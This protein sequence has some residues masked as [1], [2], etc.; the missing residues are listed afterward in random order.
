MWNSC[1][2][3]STPGQESLG[4]QC[5][6]RAPGP[7]SEKRQGVDS[8]VASLKSPR[9]N[10]NLLPP[11][12]CPLVLILLEEGTRTR[13]PPFPFRF[14]KIANPTSVLLPLAF[15]F[16]TSEATFL[17]SMQVTSAPTSLQPDH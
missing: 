11:H 9:L 15:S 10:R 3:L 17:I 8:I 1:G 14:W 13:L 7:Q 2:P 5:P 4:Q 12:I 6:Y 16:M